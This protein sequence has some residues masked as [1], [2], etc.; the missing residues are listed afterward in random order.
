MKFGRYVVLEEIGYGAFG[1]VYKV[2]SQ[3]GSVYAM[4]VVKDNDN[5]RNEILYMTKYKVLGCVYLL[6]LVEYFEKDGDLCLVMPYMRNGDLYEHIMS[7][8]FGI[9]MGK[10]RIEEEWCIYYGYE[11]A[12]AIFEIHSKGDL[13]GDI[14]PENVLITHDRSLRLADFGMTFK[15]GEI[16]DKD[17]A[18]IGTIDYV[19][20]ECER[21]EEYTFRSEFYSY[22]VVLLFMF[23]NTV[24][25]EWFCDN[26]EKI[27]IADEA[28]DLLLKL[29]E[30]PEK[31]LC[32]WGDV[33]IH[34]IFTK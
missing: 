30:L 3:D 28:K 32:Y 17:I 20:P 15:A 21:G 2:K 4:K 23:C 25:V 18:K 11:L 10:S 14:K 1:R 26:H 12:L 9:E 27:E 31:R 8:N 6:H 13:H 24:D 5:S 29:F 19:P 34:P 33:L 22:G 7:I 16:G